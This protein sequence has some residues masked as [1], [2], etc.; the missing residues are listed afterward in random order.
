[1]SDPLDLAIRGGLPEQMRA[2]LS[3]HPRETWANANVPEAAR[4]WLQMHEG[5]RRQARV[6]NDLIDRF[7]ADPACAIEIHPPLIQTLGGFLGHLDQHHNVESFHYFPQFRQV[8]PVVAA[9][10]DLLDRDHEAIH[11]HLESLHEAGLAF[12]QAVQT[13]TSDLATPLGRFSDRLRL[14]APQLARHLDDEEEIVIPLICLYG[15]E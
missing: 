14:A 10:I 6:M 15:A 5:F 2:L 12:H 1:M 4:F 3:D 9:G 11:A 13:R 8:A 7:G